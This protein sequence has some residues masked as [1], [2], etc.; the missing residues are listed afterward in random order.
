MV[1]LTSKTFQNQEITGL[2]MKGNF[3]KTKKMDLE[4]YIYQM[5]IN[6][7]VALLLIM[8]MGQVPIVLQINLKCLQENGL[9]TF[10]ISNFKPKKNLRENDFDLIINVF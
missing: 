1:S 7:Q 5:E 3:N 2:G 9:I 8:C 10:L 4:F 6:I